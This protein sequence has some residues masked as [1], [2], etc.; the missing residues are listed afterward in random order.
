MQSPGV[1]SGCRH[2][3]DDR[4]GQFGRPERPELR[5]NCPAPVPISCRPLD[6]G[7]RGA[8]SHKSLSMIVVVA[9]L[10]AVAAS[11]VVASVVVASAAVWHPV[12]AANCQMVGDPR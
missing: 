11:S 1:I 8:E 3:P 2:R 12:F 7:L 4:S 6:R 10:L 5:I 9:V